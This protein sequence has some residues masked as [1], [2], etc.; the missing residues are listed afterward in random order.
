[1]GEGREFRVALDVRAAP[2]RVWRA[3][4][5]P[6]EIVRWNYMDEV[7]ID[8]LEPGG[9]ME[10]VCADGEDDRAEILVVEAGRR[11]AYRWTSSEPEPT[12][13]EYEL[14]PIPGG[15]RLHFANRGFLEG[16]RWNRFYEADS[17][18][19]LGFHL[20]LLCLAEGREPRPATGDQ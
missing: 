16:D 13:V 18:G 9:V 11:F 17:Q 15:T 20:K 19:W 3:L 8:R 10:F 5:E 6:D 4:T 12:V 1:M 7:R 14:E 2:E